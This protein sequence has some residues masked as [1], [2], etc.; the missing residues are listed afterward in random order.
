MIFNTPIFLYV[1]LPLLALIYVLLPCKNLVLLVASLIFYAWGEPVLVLLMVVV[2][3]FNYV[4]GRLVGGNSP[5][6]FRYLATAVLLNMAVLVA[7]KYLDFIVENLNLLAPIFG[8]MPWPEPHLPLPLG[9]S[10]FIFQAVTYVVDVYRRHSAPASKF[11]DVMLYI[12]LFPQLVAGPIVRYEEVAEQ[13]RARR[14]DWQRVLN[15]AELFTTG[16][17]KKVL[18]ADSLAVPVD[19]I[20]ALPPNEL[21]FGLAWLGAI[22]F[23]LQIFFDFS[24]YSDMAIGIGRALGFDFP[25]NFNQPYR[26][27]SIQDFWRRWHMTLSRWFRDYVYIPL[28]GN[29]LGLARTY[30]NLLVVFVLTGFWHGAS[31]NYLIWGLIHGLFLVIER[32]GFAAWLNRTWA[33]LAHA[34]VAGV[35][36]L[37]WVFF[38]ADDLPSALVFLKTMAGVTGNFDFSGVTALFN[39]YVVCMLLL[40]VIVAVLPERDALAAEFRQKKLAMLRYSALILSTVFSFALIS[41]YSHKAFIYFRF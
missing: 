29:R 32:Q 10:F 26:S 37:G 13:I 17:A 40:G 41:S 12:S 16:L 22:C 23:A 11:T 7:F 27:R 20:F 5:Y 4:F 9:I 38:R 28:G 8:F 1:F 31:W 33:P 34:Y 30:I 21:S 6:R 18:I 39:P 2:A 35:V 36:L 3:W 24:G 19:R 14:S 25:D 15:G